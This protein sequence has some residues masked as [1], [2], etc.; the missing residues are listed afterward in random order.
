MIVLWWA[1]GLAFT[2]VWSTKWPQYSL[3]MTAPMCLCAGEGVKRLA[4]AVSRRRAA[5]G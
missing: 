4:P 3:I 5:P 1:I 2:L